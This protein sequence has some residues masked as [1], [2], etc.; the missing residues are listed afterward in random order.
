MGGVESPAQTSHPAKHHDNKPRRWATN[1]R[2]GNT[3]RVAGRVSASS[4]FAQ[5]GAIHVNGV[6]CSDL[7]SDLFFGVFLFSRVIRSCA[8]GGAFTLPPRMM[9]FALSFCL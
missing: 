1:G 2:T 3:A 5:D 9:S 7:G 6:Y 4:A 8:A